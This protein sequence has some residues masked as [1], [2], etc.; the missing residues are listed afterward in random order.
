MHQWKTQFIS[1]Q[2]GLIRATLFWVKAL[3]YPA[4]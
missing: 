2:S 3:R 4:K 1:R